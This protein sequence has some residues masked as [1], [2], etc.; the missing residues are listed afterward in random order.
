MSCDR[1]QL[2]CKISELGQCDIA[3]T[4][5]ELYHFGE[6]RSKYVC[7]NQN[8]TVNLTEMINQTIQTN[9]TNGKF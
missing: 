9:E 7:L 2:Y 6:R 1:E 5:A 8:G 4:S 3:L